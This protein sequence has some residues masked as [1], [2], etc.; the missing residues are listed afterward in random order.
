MVLTRRTER[1]RQPSELTRWLE[2][3]TV[4][5]AVSRPVGCND[6]VSYV[7]VGNTIVKTLLENLTLLKSL[8][9][10]RNVA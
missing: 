1:T 10:T 8:T 7:G 9:V 4:R 5:R 6:L 2:T 3:N